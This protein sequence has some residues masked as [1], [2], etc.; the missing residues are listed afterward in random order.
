MKPTL[1]VQGMH[2]MGDCLHQRAVLRQLMQSNSIML[3]TS[4]ASMYHDLVGPNLKLLR[5]ASGLRTQTKNAQR[6]G[7]LFSAF[8]RTPSMRSMRVAYSGAQVMATPS[9]TVLEAMCQVTGTDYAT[10]DYSL[11]VPDEWLD[12]LNTITG[13]IP[14]HKPLLVY[15]PLV[16]RPE[17][18]GSALRNADPA[19]YAALL[20]DIRDTFYIISVADLEPGKEWLVGPQLIADKTFHKGELDFECLAALFTLADMVFTSGGFA[21]ILAPAVGTPCV[22]VVGGY[23]PVTSMV[24]GARFAPFLAIGPGVPCECFTSMC[25]RACN[26]QVDMLAA[27]IALRDF[28]SQECIQI[29]DKITPWEGM[30]SPAVS[31]RGAATVF[32]RQMRGRR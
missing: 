9:R 31:P 19:S 20:A 25:R 32:E 5:K 8:N 16:E 23:E 13:R 27:G 6:E 15:R 21:A 17:W 22:S 26:K 10:A 29:A 1:H 4:W 3:E 28:V 7:E 2:G 14:L 30:F 12:K 24:S 11:P 18:R